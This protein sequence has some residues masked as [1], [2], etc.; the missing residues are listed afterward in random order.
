MMSKLFLFLVVNSIFC[1]QDTVNLEEVTNLRI[2]NENIKPITDEKVLNSTNSESASA[3]EGTQSFHYEGENDSK[4]G[5]FNQML[6]QLISETGLSDA[7]KFSKR[8]FKN[9]INSL[10]EKEIQTNDDRYHNDILEKI[11]S[12]VPE[13]FEAEK[14]FDF[15]NQD[16]FISS[17]NSVNSNSMTNDENDDSKLATESGE[18]FNLMYSNDDFYPESNSID[19]EISKNLEIPFVAHAEVLSEESMGIPAKEDL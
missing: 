3:V 14:I 12:V 4:T 9:I 17:I 1:N 5:K 15:I 19:N 10:I 11:L 16:L 8:E 7:T 13:S 6:H 2:T 18:D